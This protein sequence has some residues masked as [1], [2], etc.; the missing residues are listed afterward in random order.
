MTINNASPYR[1]NVISNAG[2]NAFGSIIQ[3]ALVFF[4][5]HWLPVHEFAI[6]IT[7]AA[8]VAVG[9]MLSDFGLRI[10]AQRH[11]AIQNDAATPF[12]IASSTKIVFSVVFGMALMM[13]PWHGMDTWQVSIAVLIAVTQPP[14]DPMLW[15]LRGKERLDIEAVV[16]IGWRFF[17]AV[18]I[19]LVGMLGKGIDGI[20]ITWLSVNVLRLIIEAGIN[21]IRPLWRQARQVPVA[22]ADVYK[23]ARQAMPIGLSFVLLS[24][25]HRLGVFLIGEHGTPTDVALFGAVFTLVASAGFVATSITV[26][27][28]SPLS[29]AIEANSL[30]EATAIC[31]RKL[32]LIGLVFFPSCLIGMLIGPGVIG[33]LYPP[34]YFPAGEAMPLLLAALFLSTINL[35]LKYALNALKYNWQDAASASF[36]IATFIAVYLLPPWHSPPVGAAFAWCMAEGIVFLLKLITLRKDKRLSLPILR[37]SAGA[38]LLLLG[39]AWIMTDPIMAFYQE[40]LF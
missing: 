34:N 6:Y 21:L 18:A 25:Y 33:L 32:R 26:A 14:S 7:I 40:H 31:H 36:G 19:L 16:L 8:L 10:W 30:A 15:F 5:V 17:N 13:Y 3:F 38:Y 37:T 23:A 1:K 27:G 24:L 28:F 2:A 35:A 9:E 4:L 11:F 12:A 22:L 29:R 20:L 39:I